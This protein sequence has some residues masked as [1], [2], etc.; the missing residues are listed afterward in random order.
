M[1]IN[2]IYVCW[3]LV[4]LLY[5]EGINIHKYYTVIINY[6][7]NIHKTKLKNNFICLILYYLIIDIPECLTF[8]C[9]LVT[10][11]INLSLSLIITFS[12]LA[13]LKYKRNYIM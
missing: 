7:F 6:L 8:L 11:F 13:T 3:N 9:S 12:F 10:F 5:L 2:S 4:I 1:I